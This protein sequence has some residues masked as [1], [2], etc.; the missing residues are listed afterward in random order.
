MSKNGL[1]LWLFAGCETV[2]HILSSLVCGLLSSRK[3]P[4]FDLLRSVSR[5]HYDI[6]EAFALGLNS[7]FLS[8]FFYRFLVL[9][10]SCVRSKI[11]EKK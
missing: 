3:M 9:S 7:F 6:I 1:R 2:A 4:Q 10:S 11:A 5:V 8:F